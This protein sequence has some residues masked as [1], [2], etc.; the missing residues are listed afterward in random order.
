MFFCTGVK[1]AKMC[2]LLVM[3]RVRGSWNTRVNKR[4]MTNSIIFS[5]IYRK[6]LRG[7]MKCSLVQ[8]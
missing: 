6:N 1:V 8:A 3:L 7:L 4:I 2:F 5:S